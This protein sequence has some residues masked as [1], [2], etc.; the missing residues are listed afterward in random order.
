MSLNST[1]SGEKVHIALFGMINAGKSN[2]INA[3]TN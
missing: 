3:L 2:I 1:P